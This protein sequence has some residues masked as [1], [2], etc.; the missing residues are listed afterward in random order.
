MLRSFTTTSLLEIHPQLKLVNKF[1]NLNSIPCPADTSCYALNN[2]ALPKLKWFLDTFDTPSQMYA[3]YPK[4]GNPKVSQT[5]PYLTAEYVTA[6]VTLIP[7]CILAT[8][9]ARHNEIV[10]A[11]KQIT[12][13]YDNQ[14]SDHRMLVSCY[15]N[16]NSDCWYIITS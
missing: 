14:N 3:K 10:G 9:M 6:Y 13:N 2:C 15:D 7:R 5:T 16:R 4:K 12:D 8:D 1:G 11:F